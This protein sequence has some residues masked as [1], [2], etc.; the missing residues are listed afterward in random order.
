MFWHCLNEVVCQGRRTSKEPNCCPRMNI[1]GREVENR[2]NKSQEST[3]TTWKYAESR[4]E[5]LVFR[6]ERWKMKRSLGKWPEL[7]DWSW[8]SILD[9][10]INTKYD[11]HVFTATLDDTLRKDNGA[12]RHM[13]RRESRRTVQRLQ[14]TTQSRV[15]F[16]TR[17]FCFCLCSSF[18]ASVQ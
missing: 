12:R 14:A 13:T 9:L 1:S 5:E 4:S 6:V 3:E 17:A 10:G 8:L 15:W 18:S 16:R 11:L 7:V 2:A